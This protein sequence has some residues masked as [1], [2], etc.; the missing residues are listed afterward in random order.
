MDAN[1]V[2]DHE[3]QG[4]HGDVVLDLLGEGVGE[5]GEPPVPH[6]NRQVLTLD[7]GR[8]DVRGV[9]VADDGLGR[10]ADAHGG[11]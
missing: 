3:V 1:E 5:P 2:V 9:G 4:E 10:A 6:P 11:A 7:V 8:A